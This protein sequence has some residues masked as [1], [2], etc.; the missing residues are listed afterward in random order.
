MLSFLVAC[1]AG[2]LVTAQSFY[3]ANVAAPFAFNNLPSI[4]AVKNDRLEMAEWLRSVEV[5]SLTGRP[6]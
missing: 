6:H 5:D 1:E 2:D 3:A 4:L